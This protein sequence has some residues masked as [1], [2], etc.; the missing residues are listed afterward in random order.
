MKE[1][2]RKFKKFPT[3]DE[4]ISFIEDNHSSTNK[5]DIAR[6][7][8]IKGDERILLK[9]TL[10][11]MKKSGVIEGSIHKRISLKNKLPHITVIEITGIDEDGDILAASVNSQDENDKP[12]VF[13]KPKKGFSPTPGEKYLVKLKK[14]DGEDYQADIIRFIS[15]KAREIVA[16]I[17][18]D[19]GKLKLKSLH[20]KY[21]SFLNITNSDISPYKAGELVKAEIISGNSA[22]IT[23]KL[24]SLD[25]DKISTISIVEHDIPA[26]FPDDVDKQLQSIK[27]ITEKD[28][29]STRLDLRDIPFVTID[30]EDARDFDDAVWAEQDKSFPGHWHLMVAI[31]DV[32]YYVRHLSP[33]DKEAFKRGNSVYFPDQVIPMLPEKLSNDLCSLNPNEPKACFA[34]H[35]WIDDKGKLKKHKFVRGLM[36]SIARLTYEEVEEALLGKPSEKLAPLMDKVITPLYEAYKILRKNR[37][38]RGALNIQSQEKQIILEQNKVIDIVPRKEL[39]SHNLI[40]E[41]MIT[42][43]IAAAKAL[44]KTQTNG[45]YRT[46]DKPREERVE[47][48]KKV[49][50]DLK[51][52]TPRSLQLDG[53]VFNDI[54]KST[55]NSPHSF[56]INELVLRTQSQA[57]YTV[58]NIGHFGLALKHYSH[59][60]SPIRRYS[61][62]VVH[63]ALI[64]ALGLGDDGYIEETDEALTEVGEHLCVTER[65][66]DSAERETTERYLAHY[67]EP[68]IDE[69]FMGRIISVIQFGLFVHLDDSAAEGFIPVRSLK[70]DYYEYMPDNHQ[71]KG[72]RTRKIISLGD[73]ATVKLKEANK[74]SGGLLF[75]LIGTESAHPVEKKFNKPRKKTHV[76]SD[77]KKH[78]KKVKRK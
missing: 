44:T 20:K 29:S 35:L 65:R 38:K 55:S 3:N 11:E 37:E 2:K 15:Q 64:K 58:N 66:A 12:V 21:K 22:K 73:K 7:F 34:V 24:R 27:A 14:L 51:L 8:S 40:E 52:K 78:R 42:A 45:L 33:L 17:A 26:V 49:L 56:M 13:V 62:L 77:K 32:S 6:A 19:N 72:R 50:Y 36:T 4:I 16:I 57:Q 59:F 41:F 61:D 71:F 63:R 43:N 67:F 31:A 60:T 54:L 75:E 10:K 9:K 68:K 25:S 74:W 70:D 5:N 53:K 28:L 69:I 1:K 30:G 47:N 48:L 76:K 23:K 46:H 18:D 39:T